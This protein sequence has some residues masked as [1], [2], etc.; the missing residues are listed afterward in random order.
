MPLSC[1][2]QSEQV[3]SSTYTHQPTAKRLACVKQLC[4]AKEYQQ[5]P[6]TTSKPKYAWLETAHVLAVSDK[7]SSNDLSSEAVLHLC[8]KWE[9]RKGLNE[10]HRCHFMTLPS[11]NKI[12]CLLCYGTPQKPSQRQNL[13]ELSRVFLQV[14]HW[15]DT[16]MHESVHES[17]LT[18]SAY[19]VVPYTN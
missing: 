17:V 18:M 2:V 9:G 10:I 6:N 14:K 3:H 11:F 7:L 13:R 8:W 1:I 16:H 19:N 4:Q 15:G 5:C 12:K